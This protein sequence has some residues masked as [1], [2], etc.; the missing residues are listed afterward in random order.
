MF[1][2]LLVPF[3]LK[4]AHA[5]V[6]EDKRVFAVLLWANTNHVSEAFSCLLVVILFEFLIGF[7][8]KLARHKIFCS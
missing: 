2:G 8:Q 3:E 1:L 4:Q 7:F 5:E 6:K